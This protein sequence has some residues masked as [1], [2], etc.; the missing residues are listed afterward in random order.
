ML[1]AY[2]HNENHILCEVP[3]EQL[4]KGSWINCA[5]PDT[6]ELNK[7]KTETVSAHDFQKV[8]N[9]SYASLIRNMTD[10]ENVATMLAWYEMFG[11]YHLFLDWADHLNSVTPAQVQ[12]VAQK[13]FTHKNSTVGMLLKGEEK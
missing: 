12:N 4:E 3:L 13:F 7:L 10:M 11:D 9:N 8:K 5:A 1:R 2:K 6:E